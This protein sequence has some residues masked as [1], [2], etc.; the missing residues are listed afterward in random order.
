MHLL[1]KFYIMLFRDFYFIFSYKYF[2]FHT[3][4]G[5]LSFIIILVLYFYTFPLLALSHERHIIIDIG[6]LYDIALICWYW[7]S[8]DDIEKIHTVSFQQYLLSIFMI[9]TFPFLI[10]LIS[11]IILTSEKGKFTSEFDTPSSIIF[12]GI[13]PLWITLFWDIDDL[14]QAYIRSFDMHTLSL[15]CAVMAPSILMLRCILAPLTN[16]ACLEEAFHKVVYG[17]S[18]FRYI[19]ALS[20][21]PKS[22]A[23]SPWLPQAIHISAFLLLRHKYCYH[24]MPE[25]SMIFK[26]SA[27]T[28]EYAASFSWYWA[29]LL[30]LSYSAVIAHF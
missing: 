9:Y 18:P 20:F 30:H 2:C 10:A 27:T 26:I 13:P 23:W 29:F 3:L 1:S 7:L 22:N 11:L 5:L 16:H 19:I 14:M 21:S 17:L 15:L 6:F 12:Q 4:V 8:F 28:H 24:V 25:F